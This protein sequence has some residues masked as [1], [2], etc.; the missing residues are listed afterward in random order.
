MTTLYGSMHSRANRCAWMLKELGIDFHH[1]PTNFLDGSTHNPEFLKINPNGRIPAL[2]DGGFT[3]FESLA[4]N[5]YLA[6]KAGGDLAPQNLQEDAL[7]MQW[8][9][10]VI[11]EIEK[12]L[13]LA[14]ANNLLFA[15]ESRSVEEFNL[16]VKKLSRPWDVLENHLANKE[17]IL[18]DRF[19]AADLNV[20]AVM[21]LVP[22]AN[23]D[24]SAWPNMQA[25]L[26][27]CL[28][29]PAADDWKHV[30]F[31]IPRPDSH[32]G[33]LAMFV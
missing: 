18:G 12:P 11:T 33:M 16:A 7:M 3:L 32:L 21:T 8:T 30:N 5:L 22:T 13:L 23:I 25:W 29:R 6:K 9:I 2:E 17:Y 24:I 26:H 28:E 14:S 20:A 1:E 19:S 10:W 4:I 27:K 15:P 31:T